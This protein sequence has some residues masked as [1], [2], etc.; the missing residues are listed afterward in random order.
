MSEEFDQEDYDEP[1][2]EEPFDDEDTYG[3]LEEE[4]YDVFI[5]FFN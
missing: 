3:D 4:P 1:L 5:S 2:E